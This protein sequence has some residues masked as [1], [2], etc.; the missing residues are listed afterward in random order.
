MW[1]ACHRHI[2]TTMC[3]VDSEWEAIL[4]HKSSAWCSVMTLRGGMG[5]YG[6]EIQEGGDIC[7]LTADSCCFTAKTNSTL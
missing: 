7:I 1:R 5:A 6:R 2:Y 4:Y 3:N